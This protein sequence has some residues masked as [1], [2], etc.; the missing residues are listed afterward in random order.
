M[1]I[2]R[3]LAIRPPVLLLDEPLSALRGCRLCSGGGPGF[4]WVELE[5]GHRVRA[6][7]ADVS[8]LVVGAR[9]EGSIPD[10][11]PLVRVA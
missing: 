7:V 2:A 5:L 4:G 10:G 6:E 3:A 11:C 8:G 1:A 9:V